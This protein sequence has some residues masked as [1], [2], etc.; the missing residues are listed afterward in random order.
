MDCINEIFRNVTVSRHHQPADCWISEANC[1]HTSTFRFSLLAPS[2]VLSQLQNLDVNKSAGSDGISA[3][4][5]KEVADKIAGPLTVLYNKSIQSGA[6]P[7]Q[8]KRYHMTPVHKGG[9]TSDPGN[10]CPISVVPIMAKTLEK[11]IANQLCG[12]LESHR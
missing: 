5:L 6:A 2:D 3:H 12:Y 4:F 7:L 8:W 11:L 1:E 10:F 9:G